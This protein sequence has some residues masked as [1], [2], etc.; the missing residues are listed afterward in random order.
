MS[1]ENEKLFELRKDIVTPNI[2]LRA[3]KKATMKQF[4]TVLGKI[5]KY[6]HSEWFIDLSEANKKKETKDIQLYK[7]IDKIFREH[8]LYSITYKQAAVKAAK[9]WHKKQ[10]P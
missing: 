7:L 10:S 2:Y 8:G 6:E 1:T 5:S 9:A 3:G 4:E